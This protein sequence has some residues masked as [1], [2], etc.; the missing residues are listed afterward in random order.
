M[1]YTFLIFGLLLSYIAVGQYT[2]NGSATQDNCHC[3]TLTQN[4]NTLNGSVWNNTKINLSQSFD[5][6]FQVF[7]Q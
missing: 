7:S 6:T 4:V 2:V 3:Y 1:K 5:F